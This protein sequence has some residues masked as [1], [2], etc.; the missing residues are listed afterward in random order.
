VSEY[1][2][3]M[4]NRIYHVLAESFDISDMWVN[5]ST[6]AFMARAVYDELEDELRG[7]K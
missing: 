7:A 4:V 5:T 1:K 6:M 2:E 3:E